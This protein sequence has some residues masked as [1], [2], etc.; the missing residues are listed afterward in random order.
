MVSVATVGKHHVASDVVLPTLNVFPAWDDHVLAGY[1]MVWS[2][3]ILTPLLSLTC[4]VG[5]QLGSCLGGTAVCAPG[6]APK[7]LEMGSPVSVVSLQG[8]DSLLQYDSDSAAAQ[9]TQ[10]EEPTA[11][12][13]AA[14]ETAPP[15][16]CQADTRCQDLKQTPYRPALVSVSRGAGTMCFR[17][18]L[19]PNPYSKVRT[20]SIN[21]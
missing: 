16:G 17:E 3:C 10:P 20:Q 8:D 11:L 4:L 5:Q 13:P 12:I 15:A 2:S 1:G 21:P 7:L 9:D 6:G 18:N 19:V 14:M